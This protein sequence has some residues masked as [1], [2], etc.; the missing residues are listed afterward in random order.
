MQRNWIGKSEGCEVVFDTVCGEKHLPIT[1]FTTRV[2]T[3]FGVTFMVLAPES[4]LVEI[5]TTDGQK[6]EVAEYL[7][8]VKKKTERR[9]SV[10]VSRRPRPYPECSPA[11]TAS[12]P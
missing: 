10:S 11:L 4:D 5:L 2:D 8:Y 6:K 12:I 3:I 9:P 1:I 7:E